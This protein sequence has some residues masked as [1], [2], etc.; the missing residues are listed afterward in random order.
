MRRF[1]VIRKI[2]IS[3][4]GLLGLLEQK[5]QVSKFEELLIQ[6]L[7]C[8]IRHFRRLYYYCCWKRL[9]WLQTDSILQI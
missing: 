6:V 2:L 7:R 4:Q 8:S 9:G 3:N 1:K 5:M